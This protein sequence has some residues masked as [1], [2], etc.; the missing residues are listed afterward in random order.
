MHVAGGFMRGAW[1]TCMLMSEERRYFVHSVS[2]NF[3]LISYQ[4]CIF[5]AFFFHLLT[6]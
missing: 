6:V 3:C 2:I 5:R 4:G 1:K